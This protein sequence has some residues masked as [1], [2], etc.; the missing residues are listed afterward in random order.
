MAK[1]LRTKSIV[2]GRKGS[3]ERKLRMDKQ[4]K[5]LRKKGGA[6]KVGGK[7]VKRTLGKSKKILKPPHPKNLIGTASR[8]KASSSQVS[9]S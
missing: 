3:T 8:G 5:A 6:L 4:D 7:I 9:S 2:R 1:G